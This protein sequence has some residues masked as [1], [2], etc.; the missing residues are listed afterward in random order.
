[1][2]SAKSLRQCAPLRQLTG[3]CYI[4][5]DLRLLAFSSRNRS[6]ISASLRGVH[7]DLINAAIPLRAK[8]TTYSPA[9]IAICP[10]KFQPA[11]FF[12]HFASSGVR[13]GH[14]FSWS[15]HAGAAFAGASCGRVSMR[16]AGYPLR[17]PLSPSEK[18]PPPVLGLGVPP[19]LRWGGAPA[20][21]VSL[22]RD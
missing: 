3:C 20:G 21:P 17:R 15:I 18:V 10:A 11:K 19:P 16:S 7:A 4:Q 14:V 13:F 1:M 2:I 6:Q 5:T 12:F 9:F 8:C 22:R